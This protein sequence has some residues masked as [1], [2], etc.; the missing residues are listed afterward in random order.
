MPRRVYFATSLRPVEWLI[1]TLIESPLLLLT[2]LCEWMEEI[3]I[4]EYSQERERGRKED[5]RA[6]SIN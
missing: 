4:K 5:D 3:D 1:Q 2:D 6:R